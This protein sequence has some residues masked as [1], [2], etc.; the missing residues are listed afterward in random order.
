MRKAFIKASS[1]LKLKEYFRILLFDFSRQKQ[2]N[3]HLINKILVY[4][5]LIL[6]LAAGQASYVFATSYTP[7]NE[8]G[9]PDFTN[10][11]VNGIEI[12][13]GMMTDPQGEAIDSAN[14]WLFVTDYGNNR[15]LVFTLDNNDQIASSTATYVLGQPNLTSTSCI[16][17]STMCDP[18]AIFFDPNTNYL[19]VDD[20]GG[21]A[22]FVYDLSSGITDGMSPIYAIEDPDAEGPTGVTYDSTDQ[23]LFVSDSGDRVLVYDLSGG[24][25]DFMSS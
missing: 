12:T 11:Y 2:R 5:A 17:G 13:G 3:N 24:I 14:H 25:S 19:F 7:S 8:L 20:G 15:V 9:Q 16:G 23:L 18:G 1:I 21:A 4:P 22:V 6:C 10:T